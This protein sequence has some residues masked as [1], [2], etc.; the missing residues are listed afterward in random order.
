MEFLDG[1]EAS[2]KIRALI[3]A[4]RKVRMAVAFWGDGA[5][6]ELGLEAIGAAATLICNLK[7][8]GTNPHEIRKLLNAGVTVRQSD[9]LH[10]EGLLI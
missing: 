10:V 9:I 7:S 4:S 6:T 2:A 1:N 3:G 8:G 5:T